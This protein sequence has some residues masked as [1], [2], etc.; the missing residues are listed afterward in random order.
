MSNLREKILNANDIK[1]KTV[2]VPEWDCDVLVRGM[3]GDD[4]NRILSEC[5]DVDVKTKKSKTDLVKLY[6]EVIIATAFDPQTKEKI[7][8]AEDRDALSKKNG[9]ALDVVFKVASGLSG[10]NEEIEEAEK[11]S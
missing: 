10:L 3:T 1:E 5:V 6:P 11:N 8:K 4:R 7:F 9:K 2:T